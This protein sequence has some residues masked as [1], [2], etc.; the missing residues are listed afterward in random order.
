ML[1]QATIEEKYKETMKDVLLILSKC[2][3][4]LAPK[5]QLLLSCPDV[6]R[7]PWKLNLDDKNKQKGREPFLTCFPEE[8]GWGSDQ[9]G[10]VVL[11]WSCECGPEAAYQSHILT[12]LQDRK[13][14]GNLPK[15]CLMPL[16]LCC[17]PLLSWWGSMPSLRGAGVITGIF[18]AW[19]D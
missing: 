1:G 15:Q 9:P 10:L 4:N 13:C 14:L 6:A 19:S 2:S 18:G 8:A 16:R 12:V 7:S 11:Q 5:H 17:G 3:G